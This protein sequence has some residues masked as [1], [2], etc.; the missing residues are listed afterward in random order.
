MIH[1]L[2]RVAAGFQPQPAGDLP[3]VRE[4]FRSALTRPD[5]TGSVS[6]LRSC[7][8]SPSGG[9]LVGGRHRYC[10]HALRL[11]RI[12]REITD[13]SRPIRSAI[14]VT[15]SFA[16]T[17]TAISTRSSIVNHIRPRPTTT[18]PSCH[19]TG[20]VDLPCCYDGMTPP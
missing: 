20:P 13:L 8:G 12:S 2:H 5:S 10:P 4:A 17:P 15:V 19:S 11:R 3:R 1:G 18:T 16:R 14:E 9:E 6:I 7:A